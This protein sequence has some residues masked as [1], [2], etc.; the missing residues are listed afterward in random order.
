MATRTRK[1][2]RTIQHTVLSDFGRARR[3][4]PHFL[5][6]KHK[7][8]V[9]KERVNADQVHAW[10]QL[11]YA[12]SASGHRYRVVE[13]IHVNG[14]RYVDY[15]FMETCTD[16]DLAF[17]KLKWGWSLDKVKRGARVP[18]RRLSKAYKTQLDDEIAQLRE[19]YYAAQALER[20]EAA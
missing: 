3:D 9:E 14:K 11:R 2:P 7:I 19:R 10:L 18:R 8:Y 6:Y 5:V 12:E 4:E 20:G 15:I 1:A 13:Y 17:M 16:D